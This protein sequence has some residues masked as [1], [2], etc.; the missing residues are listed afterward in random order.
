MVTSTSGG[1]TIW[2]VAA[3]TVRINGGLTAQGQAGVHDNGAAAG[4]SIYIVCKTIAGTAA[5]SLN[6][7]GGGTSGTSGGGG[8]GRIAIYF[9]SDHMGTNG[10]VALGGTSSTDIARNGTNGTFVWICTATNSLDRA[11]WVLARPAP[12]DSPSPYEYGLNAVT[13][14]EAVVETVQTP[15]DEAAGTRYACIGW[16]LT[17]SAGLVDSGSSNAAHFTIT[18]NLGL[19]WNWTSEYYLAC[20]AS[21]NG[22][23][24]ADE[25]GWYT[26]ATPVTLTAVPNGGYGFLQWSGTGVPAGGHTLNPLALS[27][28]RPRTLVAQFASLTA[29]GKTWTGTGDWFSPTNWIPPGPPGRDDDVAI[30]SGSNVLQDPVSVRTVTV[31]GTG[32]LRVGTGGDLNAALG[33][34][35]TG[36]SAVVHVTNAVLRSGGS[37]ALRGGGRL[38]AY[39]GPVTNVTNCA[40]VVELG[41]DLIVMTNSTLFLHS[42]ATN[43]GSTVFRARHVRVEAGG[44]IDG[45]SLGYAGTCGPG[46]GIGRG[47][48]G[49]GGAG[50]KAYNGPEV[51]GPTYGSSNAPAWPGSG[52]G[53]VGYGTRP[54]GGVFRLEATGMVTVD[55]TITVN[56]SDAAHDYGAGAGGSIYIICRKLNGSTGVFSARG[57]DTSDTSGGGGGGRIAIR[58]NTLD[59]SGTLTTN[60]VRGGTNRFD[61]TRSG[62]VGTLVLDRVPMPGTMFVVH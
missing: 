48:G 11:L 36:N 31:S 43:G 4:G 13:N 19:T 7:N 17:N 49:Y 3:D 12:H 25:T 23:L 46:V 32:A 54:G 37:L 8:G 62:Y 33:V 6:A 61:L 29:T 53:N 58:F 2:I 38:H 22:S 14:G 41:A 39:G 56:G 52:S 50:G 35:V 5:G 44:R 34:T 27:M 24:S 1:G 10:V 55:G 51:G 40:T 26:N 18:T 59:F 21:V 9:R 28:D 30:G 16:T 45:D 20:S 60:C 42:N 57:G 15:A 47:G